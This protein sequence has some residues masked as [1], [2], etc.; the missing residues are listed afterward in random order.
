MKQTPA[1]AVLYKVKIN[2]HHVAS[3]KLYKSHFVKI[4]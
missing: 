2:Y 3:S 4:A 1:T